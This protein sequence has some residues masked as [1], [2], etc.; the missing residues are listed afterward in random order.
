M[1]CS[2][3]LMLALACLQDLIYGVIYVVHNPLT[4]VFIK[5]ERSHA[6]LTSAVNVTALKRH[7]R[8]VS[9]CSGKTTLTHMKMES[10]LKAFQ[11]QIWITH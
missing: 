10:T 3:S 9:M 2:Q 11:A 8:C 6:L 4:S 7:T 1:V 5:G